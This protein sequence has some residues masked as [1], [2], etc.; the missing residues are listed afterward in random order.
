[1]HTL[2]LNPFQILGFYDNYI[3]KDVSLF[4]SDIINLP[5]H[6]TFIVLKKSN[7]TMTLN[8]SNFFHLE[9]SSLDFCVQN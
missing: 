7:K 3:V 4:L 5:C 9:I 2:Q 1:M 8:S 6:S